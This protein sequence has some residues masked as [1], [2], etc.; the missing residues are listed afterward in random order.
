M[1]P[2]VGAFMPKVILYC[3]RGFPYFFSCTVV[4]GLW[5]TIGCTYSANSIGSSDTLQRQCVL[6][7]TSGAG[8]SCTPCS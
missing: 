4:H 6:L 8:T 2:A 7:S 1:S 3:L 5:L